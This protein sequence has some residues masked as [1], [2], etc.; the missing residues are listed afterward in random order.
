MGKLLQL[1]VRPVEHDH[2]PR[3]GALNGPF[4]RLG[5]GICNECLDWRIKRAQRRQLRQRGKRPAAR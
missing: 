2:C 5:S 1:P 4:E 3:C